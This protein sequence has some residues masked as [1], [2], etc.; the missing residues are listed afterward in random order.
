M[1]VGLEFAEDDVQ[2][3]A[4]IIQG[5]ITG[6]GFIGSG[7]I[8]KTEDRVKGTATAASLW[9]TGVLGAAVAHEYY[10]IALLVSGVNF[11]VLQLFTRLFKE[12][13]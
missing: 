8:L 12:E 10:E 4:R 1:L 5:L 2:A 7:A 6:M 11:L 3:K 13:E 9:S